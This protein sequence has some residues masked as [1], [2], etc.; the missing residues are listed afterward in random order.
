MVETILTKMKEKKKKPEKNPPK[1]KGL[2]RNK[3]TVNLGRNK[4]NKGEKKEEKPGDTN[5]LRKSMAIKKTDDNT[6]KQNPLSK[7][8]YLKTEPSEKKHTNNKG[9]EKKDNLNKTL[10]KSMVKSKTV[11]RLSPKKKKELTPTKKPKKEE[12]KKDINKTEAKKLDKSAEKK[13]DKKEKKEDK[14]EEK[15]DKNKKENKKKEDKPK[16]EDKKKKEDK[17][18]KDDKTKKDDK[19]KKDDKNKKEQKDD[20]KLKDKKDEKKVD[21]KEEKKEEP[22][23]EEKKEE[24]KPEEKKIEDKKEEAKPEEKKVEEKKEETKPEELKKEEIKVEENKELSKPEE[25]KEET[26]ENPEEKKVEEVKENPEEKKEEPV[27]EIKQEPPKEEPE[28]KEEPKITGKPKNILLMK[29]ISK[30]DKYSPYL[31]EEDLINISKVCKKFSKPC[32][33]KLKEINDQKLSKEEKELETINTEKINLLTEFNLGKAAVK[34]SES[35]NDKSHIENFQKE[36]TPNLAIV[37][38]YRILYQLINKEKDILNEKDNV[39]FWKLFR[40]HLLKNSEKGIGNFIQEEFKNLDFSEQNIEKIYNLCE[41]QE[42]SLGPINI[43]KKDNTAKFFCFLIKE[44][45]EYIKISIG[46]SKTKKTNIGEVYKKY[47]EY[48]INKRK[49]NQQKLDK[50]ISKE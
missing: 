21:K 35:L 25:N 7:S 9:K 15:K 5:K 10:T 38:T 41:G 28:K 29:F 47:L 12:K 17:P 46:T 34:A 45:L 26:R 24:S 50:L 33:E 43:G 44:A 39:K 36:E 19:S 18:K 4:L 48:I 20:K 37:L 8:M 42:E 11:A 27:Q 6:K 22:K 32:F 3:T 13:E 49:E 2:R 1:E 14:K 16:K 31:K 30:L 40:E 23:I